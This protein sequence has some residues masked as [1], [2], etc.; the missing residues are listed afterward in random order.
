LDV[1][2]PFITPARRG[3]L[4]HDETATNAGSSAE[5]KSMSEKKRICRADK[6]CLLYSKR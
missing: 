1:V 2:K 3:N 5:Q 6:Q 4:T